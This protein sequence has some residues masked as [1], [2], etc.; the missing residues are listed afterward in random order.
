MASFFGD[1]ATVHISSGLATVK[2]ITAISNAN[3]AVVTC[4]AHG[5]ANG[6]VIVLSCGWGDLDERVI[7]IESVDANSFRLVGIDTSSVKKYPAGQGAN[8]SIGSFRKVNGFMQIRQITDVNTSG[9]EPQ[10][11]EWQFLEE[12]VKRKAPVG[13]SPR[14]ITF[15]IG[16]DPSLPGYKAA[17][18]ASDDGGLVPL[19]V[20]LAN[21]GELFYNGYCY[22]NE[23][24]SLASGELMKVQFYYALSGEF[25]RY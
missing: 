21:G 18:A 2:N 15:G 19:K 17:K 10:Y 25:T 20:V 3:P 14:D 9:G 23:M 16:D 6:D 24:P 11:V 12:K 4:T 7:K 1:G 8:A 5:L 13:V 22:L